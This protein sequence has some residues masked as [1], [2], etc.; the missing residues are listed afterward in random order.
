MTT[1]LLDLLDF[2]LEPLPVP[3]TAAAFRDAMARLGAA[4]SIVTTDGP[5]GRRGMTASAVCS[6]TDAPPT[7]LVCIKRSSKSYAAF[8]RNGV[9]AVNL[10]PA[11]RRDLAVA[12]GSGPAEARFADASEWTALATG[13]PVLKDALVAFDCAIGQTA[14]IGTHTVFFC[15]VEAVE[16]GG[17]QPGLVYFDRTYHG[18]GHAPAGLAAALAGLARGS[19]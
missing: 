13:A 4:V 11:G 8:R 18:I 17:P 12:F 19:G 2:P 1:S 6:V 7:L 16:M 10:L 5:G 3:V 15:Q 9:I 14:E